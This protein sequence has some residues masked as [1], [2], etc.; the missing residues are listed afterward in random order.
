[1]SAPRNLKTV[2]TDVLIVGAGLIGSAIAMGLSRLGV[3]ALCAVDLDLA[4]EW[5]SSELN[6]GGVRAT[7]SQK[8]NLLASKLSIEYFQTVAETI[9]YRDCGYLW[10]HRPETF[11]SALQAREMHLAHGWEVEV[12]DVPAIRARLPFIDKTGDLA[13]ALFGV[14]DGLINPNRLKEHFREESAV[15]GGRFLDGVFVTSAGRTPGGK[16]KVRAF[17]FSE[18]LKGEEKKRI[19]CEN[20]REEAAFAG[21]PGEWVEFTAE[22]IVNAAGAWAPKLATILG[23]ECPSVPVRRQISLF[24]AK[25]VDLNHY[26]MIIDP[27][28][29]Y[30]HPE[31]IYG[32][33]GFANRG[34]PQ[35]Y[36]FHYD[37]DAFFEEHIWP[38]LHERSSAFESLRHVSGWAG[39]Y[40]NSPDHH[41]IVGEV[42]G[43]G[44]MGGGT[45][46][47][48]HSFSGHGAMQSYAVG[49]ALA[50]RMVRGRYETLDLGALS[51]ARF[52][53]GQ[54]IPGETWVI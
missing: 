54:T 28:G 2:D 39:L 24:H 47:E 22:K 43:S 19:L 27:S 38:A 50:E 14:K 23:Y 41:A 1:V 15:R 29:V 31:S 44:T 8:V 6:A 7:W 32:L 12:L 48:A 40:E 21:L 11:A 51:G 46:F 16:W 52:R 37:A 25:D 42:A 3:S 17:Q 20:P 18:T 10:L 45:L 35:G 26:G 49:V 53:T 4:G 13:G 30:F 9:G 36:N 33:S 34:E 5:S